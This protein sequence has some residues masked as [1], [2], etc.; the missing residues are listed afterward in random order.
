MLECSVVLRSKQQQTCGNRKMTVFPWRQQKSKGITIQHY[1]C[2]EIAQE[3]YIFTHTMG[4]Q[5]L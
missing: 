1:Y 5:T 4:A 3:E 2:W